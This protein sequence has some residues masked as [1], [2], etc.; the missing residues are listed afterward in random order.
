MIIR[1]T[2]LIAIF[3]LFTSI[4]TMASVA[5]MLEDARRA[6]RQDRKTLGTHHLTKEEAIASLI[7]IHPITDPSQFFDLIKEKASAYIKEY[8]DFNGQGIDVLT[9]WT[10]LAY[11]ALGA[12]EDYENKIICLVALA[13]FRN[14]PKFKRLL[15]AL[16]KKVPPSENADIVMISLSKELSEIK[17]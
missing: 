11:I 3:N 17:L 9:P 7:S 1:L 10:Q 4:T 8:T 6:D 12:G 14:L 5:E 13:D 15:N 16:S 2:L